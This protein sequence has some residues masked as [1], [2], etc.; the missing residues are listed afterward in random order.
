MRVRVYVVYLLEYDYLSDRE[1]MSIYKIFGDK[2]SAE[3]MMAY[4][5][6]NL[7]NETSRYYMKEYN[8]DGM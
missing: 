7:T 6:S 8:L 3:E 5:N 1:Y 2:N 4:K